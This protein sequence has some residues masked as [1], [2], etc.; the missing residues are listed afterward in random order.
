VVTAPDP[1]HALDGRSLGRRG[2][3]TRRRL[4]D[5]TRRLLDTSGARDLRVVDVAR[6]VG[7]SPAAFYQY[8]REVDDA[9][10]VLAEEAGADALPLAELV[11]DSWTGPAGI[12]RVRR[13]VDEWLRYWD[14][15]RGVLRV[16]NLQAQE[17]DDRFREVRRRANEPLLERLRALVAAAQR[18]GRVPLGVSPVAAAAALMSLL[19]RM[20]AFHVEL[21][22]MAVDR[23]ALVETTA[24][25]VHQTVTG[26][27]ALQ[28]PA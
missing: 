6:S 19:E 21:E 22:Q 24:H 28:R 10:L 5:A 1:A 14:E 15:H 4:L 9:M 26:T 11:D 3:Q 20:A 25:I 7:T 17:G 23:T 8:F 12:E 16:R 2:A 18:D 13:L 27:P